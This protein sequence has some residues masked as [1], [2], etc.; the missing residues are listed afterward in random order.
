[1]AR[2][3][4]LALG[5]ISLARGIHCSPNFF[6]ISFAR[7]AT[8]SCEEY[9]YILYI[10]DCVEIVYELPLLPNKAASETLLHKLGAV[11]TVY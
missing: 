6:F 9:V 5:Q 10:S 4:K 1:M 7:P 3:P 11:R 8:L 2:V